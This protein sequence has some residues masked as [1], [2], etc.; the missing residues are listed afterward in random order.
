MATGQM[1]KVSYVGCGAPDGI[2][3][4]GHLRFGAV[5]YLPFLAPYFDRL[6]LRFS[7]PR[8]SSEPRTMW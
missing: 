3:P 1:A 5:A 7:T 8:E 2:R 6:C 4:L